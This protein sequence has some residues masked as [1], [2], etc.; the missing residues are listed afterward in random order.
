MNKL[1]IDDLDIAGKRVLVRVDFN[2]PIEDGKV[3]NDNR[4]VASLPTI[5]KILESGGSA[6]LMSHLGR[7]KGK[8]DPTMSLKPVAYNLS[9]H[10]DKPVKFADDCIGEEALKQAK[11]LKP[12][13]VLLLENLRFYSGEKNNDPDFAEKLSRLG[14]VYINDA[15]GTAHR[16]HA[17]TEGVTKY[18][19]QAAAGYL[20][21][22][23]IEYLGNAV[24]NP[25]RP[26]A[27]ILG[28][29]KISGKIDVINNLI[30][31][32]EKIFI[33]GGMAFTFFKAQG[34]EIGKSLLEEDR[35]EMAEKLLKKAQSKEVEI[36]LP[37]DVV[38]ARDLS[39]DS[40]T[41]TV[42]VDQIPSDMAGYDIGPETL[43]KYKQDLSDCRTI[44]WNGPMGVFEKE[45]F[46]TG[47]IE[48]AKALAELTSEGATTII[49]G[50]DSASAVKKAGVGDRLSH[51]STGGGASLEFL[52]GKTLPGLA[53]L[54]DK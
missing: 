31:K 1:T 8:S 35:V 30:E 17:S 9:Q 48:L 32:V 10:L 49:G 53:A 7:P 42:P 4:I 23:E 21:V 15:F 45:N 18:F 26:M 50:G 12:G 20:M 36:S 51:I 47:T 6:V 38:C 19:D 13:E 41:K 11:D 16:A 22:K 54:T 40:E 39:E 28:G 46:A 52:E 29:A 27:A 34:L 5:K 33:G 2:V 3:A 24:E 37:V 43:K 14:E 25:E 44:V